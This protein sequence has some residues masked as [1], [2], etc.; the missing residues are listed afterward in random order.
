MNTQKE[1]HTGTVVDP[2]T[3]GPTQ[4]AI[5]KRAPDRVQ[6]TGTY[7]DG[8]ELDAKLTAAS[9]RAH[10][11]SPFSSLGSLPA[12]FGVRLCAVR[13][14][15][16]TETYPIPGSNKIGLSKV[17]LDRIG[18]ALG[19]SWDPQMSGRLDDG[20]DPRY[21]RYRAVGS[22]LGSDGI[23]HIVS[24]E[25][26]MDMRAGSPT[27]EGLEA[28]AKAKGKSAEGQVREQLAHIVSHAETKARLRA[29]RSMGIRTAYDEAELD[30]PFVAACVMF[31]GQ[32]DDPE[33]ARAFALMIARNALN[34]AAMLFAPPAPAPFAR[35]SAPPIAASVLDFDDDDDEVGHDDRHQDGNDGPEIY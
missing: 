8:A 7:H 23:R 30:K 4:G 31:T 6:I 27:V 12:G 24:A 15:I 3:Q 25:K 32:T 28:K 13:V 18:H 9:S 19:L 29:I 26:E 22:Y 33:L 16:R 14:D 34:G 11:I 17:A 1:A 5:E 2:P 35:T 20:R 10:L 21:C